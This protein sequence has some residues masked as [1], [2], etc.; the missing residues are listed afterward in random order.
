MAP[1]F[2]ESV[3]FA[4]EALERTLHLYILFR[5][6][7]AMD[8]WIYVP[9]PSHMVALYKLSDSCHQ[10]CEP[11]LPPACTGWRVCLGSP[12]VVVIMSRPAPLG[13][14]TQDPCQLAELPLDGPRRFTFKPPQHLCIDLATQ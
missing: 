7:A 12:V 9:S 13:I 10:S 8:G 5:S 11:S 3:R 4:V 1:K 2:H 14:L 6:I